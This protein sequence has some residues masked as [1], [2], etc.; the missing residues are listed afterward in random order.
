[1]PV[2][3]GPSQQTELGGDRTKQKDHHEM[4]HQHD[5]SRRHD[6]EIL[7]APNCRVDIAALGEG[8]EGAR[9]VGLE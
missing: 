7:Y 3:P 8:R 5:E 9:H 2:P 6:G 4:R 1:M